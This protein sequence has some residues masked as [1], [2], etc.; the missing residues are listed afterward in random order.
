MGSEGGKDRVREETGG[1]RGH[2]CACKGMASRREQSGKTRGPGLFP[3]GRPRHQ[4]FIVGVFSS[5]GGT[6]PREL[7]RGAARARAGPRP[8]SPGP[9]QPAEACQRVLFRVSH[10]LPFTPAFELT[11]TNTDTRSRPLW[12]P[13]GSPAS[14]QPGGCTLGSRCRPQ[15]AGPSAGAATGPR[16]E[17]ADAARSLP[18]I[19]AHRPP[20]PHRGVPLL[21]ASSTGV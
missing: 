9:G 5:S 10:P 7:P 1:G 17:L 13:W 4:C 19:H 8:M 2:T 16:L 6:G 12:G 11:E 14:G 3:A 18:L 15:P 21:Q 20:A